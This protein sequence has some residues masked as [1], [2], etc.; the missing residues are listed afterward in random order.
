MILDGT[1]TGPGDVTEVRSFMDLTEKKNLYSR[2]L[3]D[4]SKPEFGGF[5]G[6]TTRQRVENSI[7]LSPLSDDASTNTSAKTLDFDP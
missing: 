3:K 5:S 6:F 4:R 7:L 1:R 2:C